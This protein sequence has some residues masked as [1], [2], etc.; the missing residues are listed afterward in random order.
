MIPT[1]IPTETAPLEPAERSAVWKD[2]MVVC[3]VRLRTGLDPELPD[4][5]LFTGYFCELVPVIET[6]TRIRYVDFNG[7]QANSLRI[8]TGHF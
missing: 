2:W 7:L 5:C 3:A 4:K 6:C 1:K 8:G